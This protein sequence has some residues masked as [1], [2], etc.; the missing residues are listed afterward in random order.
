MNRR[1]GH[2][3]Q[4]GLDAVHRLVGLDPAIDRRA[5]ELR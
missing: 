4:P 5:R 1:V 3:A 2:D